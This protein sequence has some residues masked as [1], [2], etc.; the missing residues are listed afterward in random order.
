[1]AATTNDKII[2][3]AACLLVLASA[4]GFGTLVWRHVGFPAGEVPTVELSSAAYTPR[5]AEAPAVKTETWAAPV[6]QSRGREWI[7]DTFTPPEIFYNVRSKQFTVKPPSGLVEEELLEDFGIELVMVRP[8]PF[9][10][11]MIGYVGGE[12][13]WR[14]MFQNVLTGEVFL[15][16]AGRRI[17]S[18]GLAIKSLEVR[19]QP[20]RSGESMVTNQRVATAVIR[21]EKA[22][23]DVVLTHRERQFTG[24]ISAFV[25]APGESAT[26]EVKNGDVFKIGEATYRVEAV[27]FS[28]PTLEITKEAPS[29][30][31]P[32]RRVLTPRE[33][34]L[35]PDAPERDGTS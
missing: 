17:P 35:P 12:G 6:A 5:G 2:I 14:G 15:A 16:S 33:A 32:D 19:P 25:A 3:G 11:Q 10:L 31:Q 27:K 21:D 4:G 29:L 22:G 23:S 24:L 28:P 30:T 18:L 34:E 20:V 26:R 8:E 9:R 7:Y 13:S 1:M